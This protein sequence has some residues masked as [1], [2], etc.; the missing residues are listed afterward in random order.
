MSTFIIMGYFS[1]RS[2]RRVRTEVRTNGTSKVVYHMHYD[3]SVD[4]SQ[5][6]PFSAELRKYSPPHDTV[7]QDDTIASVIAKAYIPPGNVPGSIILEAIRMAPVPVKSGYMD[8]E[9]E[10]RY[11]TVFAHGTVT[12][13]HEGGQ[14]GEVMFPMTTSNYVRGS[15]KQTTL[16]CVL[17]F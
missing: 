5:S 11:P 14:G 8:P 17:R 13:E 1:L 10:F 15:T 7:L 3:T 12:G 6:S 2:G 16:A 9:S 4:C